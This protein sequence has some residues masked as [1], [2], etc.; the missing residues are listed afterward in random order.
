MIKR[1]GKIPEED[2]L[3][4]SVVARDIV[5][6]IRDYGVSQYQITKIVYLL[7]LELEDRNL[8]DDLVTI[9]KSALEEETALEN[10]K[11]EIITR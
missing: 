5:K 3:E 6:T 9:T 8:A 10:N 7:S 4:Q 2:K 1:Y 11:S